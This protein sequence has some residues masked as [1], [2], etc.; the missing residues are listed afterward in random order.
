MELTESSS[1]FETVKLPKELEALQTVSKYLRHKATLGHQHL[2][3]QE[4]SYGISFKDSLI[5]NSLSTL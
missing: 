5:Q 3:Q 1:V 2:H 4:A